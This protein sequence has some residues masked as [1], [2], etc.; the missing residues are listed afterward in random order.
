MKASIKHIA[1]EATFELDS[2]LALLHEQYGEALAADDR[3]GMLQTSGVLTITY[4]GLDRHELAR[5]W[6]EHY[7]ELLQKQPASAR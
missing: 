1:G 7:L 4:A 3:E 2:F 5:R 6:A